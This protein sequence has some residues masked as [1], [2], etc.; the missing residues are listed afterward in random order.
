M[1][2]QKHYDRLIET[3]KHRSIKEGEYYET[4]HVIMRSMGG[5]NSSNNTVLLTSREHFLAHW[6]LW[7]IHKNQK[8][9]FAFMKQEKKFLII[10]KNI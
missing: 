10:E 2:Y 5:D 8:T 7:R 4:H 1:N 3:R 6:L 9:A